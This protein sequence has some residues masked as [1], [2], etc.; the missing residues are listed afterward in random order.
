MV[1]SVLRTVLKRRHNPL[2]VVLTCV[3]WYVV[4]PLRLR[5]IEE[6]IA[7]NAVL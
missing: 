2:E 6:M 1:N 4:Y 3:R 7:K 5:H